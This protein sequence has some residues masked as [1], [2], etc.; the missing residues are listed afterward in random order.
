M[1]KVSFT[2]P[3]NSIKHTEAFYF[4]ACGVFLSYILPH[5]DHADLRHIKIPKTV[6]SPNIAKAPFFP[7]FSSSPGQLCIQS[8]PAVGMRAKAFICWDPVS[9]RVLL[10]LHKGGQVGLQC[11]LNRPPASNSRKGRVGAAA[12][13]S[14]EWNRPLCGRPARSAAA[15]STSITGY[16]GHSGSQ[17]TGQQKGGDWRNAG[18]MQGR[19]LPGRDLPGAPGGGSTAL[20]C[21]KAALLQ[22]LRSSS[23]LASPCPPATPQCRTERGPLLPPW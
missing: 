14:Q 8:P 4:S 5:G 2:M 22:E 19:L 17:G 16:S 12:V 3:C 6:L 23:K 7:F 11:P 15:A 13:S 20:R 21:T 1:E 10:P 9:T 18:G